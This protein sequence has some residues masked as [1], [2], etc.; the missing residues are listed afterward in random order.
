MTKIGKNDW[1]PSDP[2]HAGLRIVYW[3]LL[4]LDHAFVHRPY[5]SC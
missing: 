3:P 2:P 4:K 1:R 5:F